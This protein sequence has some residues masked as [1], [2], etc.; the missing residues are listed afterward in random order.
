VFRQPG[1]AAACAV[2]V[3]VGFAL[4]MA[5]ANVP[6]FIHTRLELF[7]IGDPTVLRRGA[8]DS[9]WMLSALTLTMAALAVPGGW[10]TARAGPRLPALAGLGAALGGF[11]LM[12]TWQPGTGYALMA[13]QLVIT[14]I[15]LG[16]VIS[17]VATVVINAAGGQYHGSASALVITLRLIGMTVG[18]SV[19]TLWGVRRQDVLRRAGAD[20]PLALNDPAAFLMQVAAQVIGETFLFAA[21]A[22]LLALLAALLLGR[23]RG[24]AG[25]A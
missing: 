12:S 11:V 5:L 9:G 17:P 6:L 24:G 23:G 7:N 16:L 1:A 18:V 15:G 20:D 21:A 3:L 25:A 22:C 10:F 19:L 2:N 14:G 8:W 13:L 4:A